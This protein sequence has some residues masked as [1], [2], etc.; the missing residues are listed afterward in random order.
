[1]TS[2]TSKLPSGLYLHQ[3]ARAAAYI[4]RHG[5]SLNI[6]GVAVSGSTVITGEIAVIS[7][8]H[9]ATLGEY[10]T[11]LAQLATA[12]THPDRVPRETVAIALRAVRDLLHQH[13]DTITPDVVDRIINHVAEETDVT[14]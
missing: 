7:N 5:R 9:L 14:L 10:L 1:M 13:D 12:S 6:D 11:T 8:A 3:N 4:D 2:P